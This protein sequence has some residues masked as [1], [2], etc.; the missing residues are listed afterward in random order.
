MIEKI[1]P[2]LLDKFMNNLSK[3]YKIDITYS[4]SNEF[5]IY[6]GNKYYAENILLNVKKIFGY[7]II[8]EEHK[9][10]TIQTKTNLSP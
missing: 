9:V 7:A 8:K 3:N 6:K 1:D 4:F 2:F 10:I 5:S